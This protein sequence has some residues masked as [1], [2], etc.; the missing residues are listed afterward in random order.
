MGSCGFFI[1][2]YLYFEVFLGG[3]ECVDLVLWFVK[4]GFSVGNYIG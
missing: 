4:W 2:L 3:I 1:G